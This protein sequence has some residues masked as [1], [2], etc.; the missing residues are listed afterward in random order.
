M[1]HWLSNG[2]HF[3][4]CSTPR[5]KEKAQPRSSKNVKPTSPG[6]KTMTHS[7][8]S[9]AIVGAGVMGAGIAQI[10]AQAGLTVHLFDVRDGAALAA[11]ENIAIM[12][13]KLAQKGKI[14]AADAEAAVSRL[15]VSETLGDLADCELVIEAIVERLDAKQSLLIDLEAVVAEKCILATNTSSLSVTR[16]ASTC[17]HPER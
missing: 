7:I 11:R 3:S 15:V 13:G 5:T 2:R 16:L 6:S 12:L 17:R 4:F 10:S 14:S 1:G 9:M 8:N